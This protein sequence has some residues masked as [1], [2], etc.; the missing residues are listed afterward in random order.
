MA[1]QLG[2]V[3]EDGKVRAV[4]SLQVSENKQLP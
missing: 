4:C 2:A 3:T 1:M